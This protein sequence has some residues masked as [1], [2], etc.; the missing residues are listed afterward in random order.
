[1]NP[2][3]TVAALKQSDQPT[4]LDFLATQL[5]QFPAVPGRRRA[6][7][8]STGSYCPIHR[9]HFTLF[10]IAV[11]YLSKYQNID[12]LAGFLSPSADVW[13]VHKLGEKAIPFHHRLRMCELAVEEHNRSPPAL[14]I[15]VDPWEGLQHPVFV[16]LMNVR[17]RLEKIVH[18]VLGCTELLVIY[19]AGLDLFTRSHLD[20]DG[21]VIAIGRP[22]FPSVNKINNR[23]NTWVCDESLVE[24]AHLFNDMSSTQIRERRA[25]NQSVADLTFPCVEEYL[26]ELEKVQVAHSQ[27]A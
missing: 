27:E 19:V 4:P 22:P 7:L 5:K 20:R 1:M 14:H 16:K 13:V 2:E 6:I 17:A 18:E 10:E 15:V 26:N 23:P 21:N 25:A 3:Q 12:V 8:L 24:F 11:Q 9:G